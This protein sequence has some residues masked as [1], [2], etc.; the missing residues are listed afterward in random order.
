LVNE[1]LKLVAFVGLGNSSSVEE[2]AEWLNP[3]QL[4]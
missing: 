3:C 1:D 2:S 4:Y